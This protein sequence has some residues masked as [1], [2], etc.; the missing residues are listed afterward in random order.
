MTKVRIRMPLPPRESC[1]LAQ[2]L[3]AADEAWQDFIFA[4]KQLEDG[5]SIENSLTV[6]AAFSR[7]THELVDDHELRTLLLKCFEQRLRHG[8]QFSITRQSNEWDSSWHFA[9]LSL[10][11]TKLLRGEKE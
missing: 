6:F 11:A 3:Q 4:Q 8:R 5:E 2:R 9:S 1:T 10:S 7:F